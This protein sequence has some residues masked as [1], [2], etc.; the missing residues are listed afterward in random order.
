MATVGSSKRHLI[1]TSDT[2]ESNGNVVVGG[3]LTINGTTTTIDTANLLVEDKN[4]IIGSVSSPTDTTADGGGI[5]LKGASDYT[6]NWS[7]ANNRWEFNQGIHSTGSITGSNL[8]GTNTGDQDLSGYLL[9]TGKAA[10][11]NLLDGI[12]SGSFLRSDA[13]DTATG[14]ITFSNSDGIVLDGN[15]S[16]P[17]STTATYNQGLTIEGGNMRL[18]IDVSNVGNGGAYIQTRHESTTY[19]NAY[20]TLALNPLGGNV[21]INGNTA[22][23]AANDGSGSGLDAD[24]LDGKQPPTNF[25]ATSQTYTTIPDGGWSLPTGSSIFSQANSVG[26]VGDDG[27]WF[28]TGRRDVGGGYSGIYTPHSNGTA[29]LGMSLTGTANPT[30]WKIWTS[31]NDGPGS[32]L[33]A[34]TLDGQ[35][36]S[37]FALTS[38]NHDGDYIQD[39]GTNAIGNI[40][41]IGT[42][43]IKHRWNNTTVGRPAELSLIHI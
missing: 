23:H 10:D 4:I 41:T 38:H 34:D 12:D 2:Y 14:Y 43:S 13:N 20:Y 36:A 19:P 24:L 35:E 7:S 16:T 18:N 31:G 30:W 9:I 26:G 32:G 11:S 39:G 6:I 42:E 8:S 29:W 22:W 1:V 25:S 40:N 28:V 21:T 27:Y 3:D 15:G 37:A 5:T 17:D 33:D